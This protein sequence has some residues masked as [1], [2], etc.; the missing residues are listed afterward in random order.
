M[1]RP[2]RAGFTLVELLVVIGIIAV[3]IGILLPSLSKA[4]QAAVTATCLSNL[5]QMGNAFA[6]YVNDNNNYLPFPT[7]SHVIHNSDGSTVDDGEPACW[8]NAVDQY[9]AGDADQTRTGV[10][11]T[12][13][14]SPYKQCPVWKSFVGN[15]TGTGQDTQKEGART[16]KMNTHLRHPPQ[17]SIT[18]F[19]ERCK[20]TDAHPN[21]NWVVLGDAQA[22]DTAGEG[23]TENSQFSFECNKV[24]NT[25]STCPALRHGNDS[26]NLLLLDGHAENYRFATIERS[27]ESPKGAVKIKSF[28]SEYVNSSGQPVKPSGLS[29]AESQ[30]L[31]QNPNMPLQ[32]SNPPELYE[33][34]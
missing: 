23:A 31:T 18:G 11:K 15:R 33:G 19:Q 7:T 6:M 8:F 2:R 1:N 28:Q 24:N 25:N 14:F 29:S 17:G 3:L 12:R 13:V 10:A 34:S 16:Y 22:N 21:A 32:W 5:R 4:R 30:G 26:A 9:L 20:I 27:L